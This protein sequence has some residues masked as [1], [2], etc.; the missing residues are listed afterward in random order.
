MLS[1]P[2]D[3]SENSPSRVY[4]VG[5][6]HLGGN[7]VPVQVLTM[8]PR[9]LPGYPISI[10]VCRET[11]GSFETSYI[12]RMP[13]ETALGSGTMLVYRTKYTLESFQTHRRGSLILLGCRVG[14][15]GQT[16]GERCQPLGVWRSV[17]SVF[18][19][20]GE[21]PDPPLGASHLYI[22]GGWCCSRATALGG[23]RSVRRARG[24][25]A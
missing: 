19:C 18:V 23:V 7:R 12:C 11:H 21:T 17:Y 9:L 13:S 6:M 3:G 1:A 20:S 8:Q 2:R 15:G 10:S 22:R 25:Q 5:A 16:H 24:R 14:T 4:L